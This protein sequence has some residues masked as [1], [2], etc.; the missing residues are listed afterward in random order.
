MQKIEQLK[1][2]RWIDRQTRAVIVEFTIYSLSAELAAVVQLLYEKNSQ[3]VV[4]PFVQVMPLE[5]RPNSSTLDSQ[6]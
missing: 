3:G 1:T 5:M 4:K 2:D 6:P